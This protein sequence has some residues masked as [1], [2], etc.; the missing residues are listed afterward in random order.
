[1]AATHH[2]RGLKAWS[3]VPQAENGRRIHLATGT[4]AVRIIS[5]ISYALCFIGQ[6]EWE[7]SRVTT[8]SFFIQPLAW[9]R[10]TSEDTGGGGM[11]VIEACLPMKKIE[12]EGSREC[13]GSIAVKHRV[14]NH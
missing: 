11:G 2:I 6:S 3:V 10:K 7:K 4:N 1:M 12:S 8:L 9:V 5:G 13:N 14:L